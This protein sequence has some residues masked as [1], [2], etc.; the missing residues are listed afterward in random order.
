[1]QSIF[2]QIL[3]MILAGVRDRTESTSCVRLESPDVLR[4][5]QHSEQLLGVLVQL[6]LADVSGRRWSRGAVGAGARQDQR[7]VRQTVFTAVQEIPAH[8]EASP[9]AQYFLPEETFMLFTEV[10]A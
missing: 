2:R 9:T 1:M 6:G 8:T 10:T 5:G 3:E 7:V 4:S